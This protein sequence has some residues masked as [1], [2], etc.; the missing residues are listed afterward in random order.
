MK[1][2][3][4]IS[5][6]EQN[7]SDLLKTMKVS[8]DAVLVNQ[9]ESDSL[10]CESFD[11]HRITVVSQSKRG[12][13]E[14][15]NTAMLNATGDICLFS[16]ED[17][18]YFDDYEKKVLDAFKKHE[19]A[20][21]ITFN[22]EVD[23][24]R[25]TYWNSDVHEIKWNN[26]GRYPA[27]SIAVKRDDIINNGIFYSTLFGGGAKYSNGEDSLFLH[28]CLKKGL[29]MYSETDILGKETY[30]ESTWFK[31]YTDKFFF[32]RGVLYHF[33]YGKMAVLFG[34]RFLLKNKNTMLREK[35]FFN[36]FSLL[37]AGVREGKT[38]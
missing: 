24:R 32:D 1:F 17:I 13:G 21:V 33:L 19:D 14:S 3:L 30:R 27:Y 22:V 28:D 10:A 7:T 29:K 11:G 12:V 34:A 38:L 16:D 15:R 25:R 5:S 35:S 9:C 23:E 8:S 36:A 2:Q 4:L 26:Y 18:V 31:G 20:S 6:V 37:R